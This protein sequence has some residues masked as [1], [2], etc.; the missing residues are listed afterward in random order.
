MTFSNMTPREHFR[1]TGTV[2]GDIL[3]LLIEKSERLAEVQNIDGLLEDARAQF[4]DEDFLQE[5]ID[6]V[7][8]LAKNLRGANREAAAR[9]AQSL[10]SISM[11]TMR[12]SEYGREQINLALKD[13]E[14]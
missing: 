1:L 11:T 8:A 5:V 12:S 3:E 14:G 6:R 9:I 4:P 7:N 2:P 13:L 10:D